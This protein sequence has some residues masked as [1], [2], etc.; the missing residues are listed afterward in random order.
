MTCTEKYLDEL[1]GTASYL[2]TI[3]KIS[4]VLLRKKESTPV[5]TEFLI[6]YSLKS[7]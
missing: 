3:S 5:G 4:A 1:I 6:P 2:E 7:Q